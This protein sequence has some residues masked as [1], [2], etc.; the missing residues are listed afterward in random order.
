MI[1]PGA[2]AQCPHER[3]DPTLDEGNIHTL[4]VQTLL[5]L[6][7]RWQSWLTQPLVQVSQDLSD[8]DNEPDVDPSE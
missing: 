3:F 7:S 5:G 4:P 2:P 6:A 1:I 8:L